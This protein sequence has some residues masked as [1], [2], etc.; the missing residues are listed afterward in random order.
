MESRLDRYRHRRKQRF[1]RIMK[2]TIFIILVAIL[3]FLIMT[4]N[5]TIIELNVLD[6]TELFELDFANKSFSFLGRTYIINIR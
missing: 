3:S 4:V 2:F 6:N 5:K 1:I